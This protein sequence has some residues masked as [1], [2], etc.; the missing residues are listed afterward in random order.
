[1]IMKHCFIVFFRIQ[2]LSINGQELSETH[3]CNMHIISISLL[4]LVCR[5]TGI[6]SLAEYAEKIITDRAIEASHLLPPLLESSGKYNMNIPQVMMD[7]VSA[8]Y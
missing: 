4:S 2:Q 6:K 1:M 7:K 8:S 5:V 3:R